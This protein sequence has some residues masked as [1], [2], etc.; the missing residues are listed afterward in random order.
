MD[1]L[2]LMNLKLKQE[3]K[4]LLDVLPSKESLENIRKAIDVELQKK[5]NVLFFH[6]QKGPSDPN[7]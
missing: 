2:E 5:S 4:E 1:E 6:K 3:L 7:K